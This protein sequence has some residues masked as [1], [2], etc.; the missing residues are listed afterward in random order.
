VPMNPVRIALSP[1]TAAYRVGTMNMVPDDDGHVR[2]AIGLYFLGG[3]S[4]EDE[5]LV[6]Q[7]IGRCE[8][9]LKEYDDHSEV[10]LHL[11]SLDDCAV[12][13]IVSPP[14]GGDPAASDRAGTNGQLPDSAPRTS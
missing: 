8:S 14:D 10:P 4:D 7:H 5:A 11:S 12:D 13:D 9:C 6:E 3:L 2:G 1:E